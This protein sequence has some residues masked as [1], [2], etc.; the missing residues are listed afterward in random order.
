MEIFSISYIVS[1]YYEIGKLISEMYVSEDDL[2]EELR[3]IKEGNNAWSGIHD[4]M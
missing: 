2:V 3:S 1:N 4:P